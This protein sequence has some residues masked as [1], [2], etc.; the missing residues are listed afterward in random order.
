MLCVS[1]ISKRTH[2]DTWLTSQM[3]SP[4]G[5]SRKPLG[6]TGQLYDLLHRDSL[7]CTWI[8]V[9]KTLSAKACIG[10]HASLLLYPAI[11]REVLSWYL[12]FSGVQFHEQDR[13]LQWTQ[14]EAGSNSKTCLR[15]DISWDISYWLS[16]SNKRHIHISWVWV[17]PD[18]GDFQNL[19]GVQENVAEAEWSEKNVSHNSGAFV[20]KRRTLALFFPTWGL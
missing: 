12:L 9:W 15:I 10:N 17:W 7:R 14:Q 18:S 11:F 5:I 3:L 1:I 2:G 8:N 16:V 13:K 19:S 6:C 20:G 4:S